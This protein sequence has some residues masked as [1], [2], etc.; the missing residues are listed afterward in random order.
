MYRSN[1]KL[2]KVEG[3]ILSRKNYGEADRIVSVFS[4][5][6]GKLRLMAKGVR[7]ISSR[8][9]PHLEIFTHCVLMVRRGNGLDSISDTQTIESFET[10]RSHLD[11]V[12]LAYFY[13]ELV[14]ALLADQQEHEDIFAML[15]DALRSLNAPETNGKYAESREFTLEL[16]WTLGFLPRSK[17]LTG[18][19]LQAFVE[20]VTER[21]LTS[22]K[23][24]R[25][26][27]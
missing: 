21:S 20:S 18:T 7:K 25:R 4:K 22:P 6:Y 11:R 10:I 3:I 12:G 15:L 9:A 1:G 8:R 19:K 17:R 5:E 14:A 13:C 16:L 26:L 27:I 23:M 24:V 2:Y